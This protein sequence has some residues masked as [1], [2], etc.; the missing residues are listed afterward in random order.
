MFLTIKLAVLTRLHK[1]NQ[2]THGGA[3]ILHCII[4]INMVYYYLRGC[5][6]WI[7]DNVRKKIHAA[8]AWIFLLND[9]LRVLGWFRS[10]RLHR[11]VGRGGLFLGAQD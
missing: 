1:Y 11:N 7:H 3:N 9:V 6:I 10:M 8:P 4:S 2:H 5:V